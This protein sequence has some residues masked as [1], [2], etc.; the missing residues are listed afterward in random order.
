MS[1]TTGAGAMMAAALGAFG[2]GGG[3]AALGAGGFTT[4][5]TRLPYRF[6]VRMRIFF[7]MLSVMSSIAFYIVWTYW[8]N[9]NCCWSFYCCVG[10]RFY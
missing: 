8:F 7:F 2:F 6:F 4:A 1:V 3:A 9:W 5:T 10:S